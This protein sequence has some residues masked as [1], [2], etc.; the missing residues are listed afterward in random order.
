MK[1][2]VIIF[3]AVI[4]HSLNAWEVDSRCL[5]RRELANLD[6]TRQHVNERKEA[7]HHD[8]SSVDLGNFNETYVK[9]KEYD[10]HVSEGGG[11]LMEE[12]KPPDNIAAEANISTAS[13]RLRGSADL[14]QL[15]SF[16]FQVKMY[17][18]Q[19]Y[20]VSTFQ[21]YCE[22]AIVTRMSVLT[23]DLLSALSSSTVAG[24]MERTPVV[25]E[26]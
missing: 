20:C 8:K 10:Y 23:K 18:E 7:S 25:L 3:L 17:W 12:S 16:T 19:E 5:E 1:P 26:V 14:R 4:V 22:R 13:R 9:V 15:Q 6:A 24:R 11:N 2:F 21:K